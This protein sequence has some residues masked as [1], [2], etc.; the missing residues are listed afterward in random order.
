MAFTIDGEPRRSPNLVESGGGY[1]SWRQVAGYFDGDGNVGLEIV[2]RVLHFRLRFV[3][4]ARPQV[5]SIKSFLDRNGIVTG[6]VGC[7]NKN[8]RQSVFRVE[9]AQIASVI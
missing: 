3:D 7:D 4:T 1:S 6:Q 2:K 8:D 5:D 9:V